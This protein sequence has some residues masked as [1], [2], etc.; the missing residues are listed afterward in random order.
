MTSDRGLQ[1]RLRW[2]NALASMAVVLLACGIYAASPFNARQMSA[3]Y[4][5]PMLSF[6]GREFLFSTAAVYAMLLLLYAQFTRH[7]VISKSLRFWRLVLAFARQPVRTW[8]AGL[9]SEDRLA[10]LTTLLKVFFAPLMV[11]SLMGFCMSAWINGSALL[12]LGWENAAARV[13]FDRFG[14]WFLM[15]AI[16]FVDVLVFTVGYLVESPRLGNQ[17]RSVDPTW[18][19]WAVTL[20]CYP[21]FNQVT[22]RL[23]GSQVSDFPRFDDATVHLSL[24]LLLLVLMAVYAAASVAMGWKASNLTHRGIVAHGPYAIVRHPAYVCKNMAW[25]IG[26]LPLVLAA[27]DRGLGAGLTAIAS[28]VAWSAIYVMR[29]LTEEAHLRSVDPGYD[30]YAARVRYRFIPG[31]V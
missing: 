14:F 8:K 9:P 12:S 4:G 21:P 16:L 26:A 1:A 7:T 2:A 20:A 22:V 24:N 15:Q 23:I 28:V 19:G 11:M 25:W 31:L 5:P 18:L 27:F 3:R 17:I 10:L 6:G 13:V 30:A 29:A